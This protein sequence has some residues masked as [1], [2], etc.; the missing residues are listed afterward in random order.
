VKKSN[1][2]K[3]GDDF[4]A[5]DFIRPT[6]AIQH[7]QLWPFRKI[8]LL[9]N[10]FEP[11]FAAEETA[12]RTTHVFRRTVL[13]DS[14]GRELMASPNEAIAIRSRARGFPVDSEE[15]VK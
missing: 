8:Q 4:I 14:H 5:T 1:K 6:V 9:R 12:Y 7:F 3:C 10:Q 2:Q 11:L 13:I 15:A